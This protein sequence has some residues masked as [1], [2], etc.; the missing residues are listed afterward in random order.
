MKLVANLVSFVSLLRFDYSLQRRLVGMLMKRCTET[1][2]IMLGT[3]ELD[4]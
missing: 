4:I 3:Q 1:D 2:R